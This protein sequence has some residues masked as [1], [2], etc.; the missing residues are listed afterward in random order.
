MIERLY[1]LARPWL[2]QMDAE[3][4][5]TLTIAALGLS[6]MWGGQ[7]KD[8]LRLSVETMGIRFPNPVGLA[9]GFDKNADVPDAML[10]L[11][12]GFVEAGT[13]TPLPQAGNPKPRVFRLAEDRGVI[14]RL[15]FNNEGLAA[16]KSRLTARRGR[17]GIV[18]INAGANKDSADRIADYVNGMAQLGPLASYVTIN[19]SS[20]NTPGLRGLQN[21]DELERLLDAVMAARAAHEVAGPTLLKIAPDLDEQAIKDIV[22]TVIDRRLDGLIV[23]NTTISRPDTLRSPERGET[24]G[25]SGAPLMALSTDT[26][27]HVAWEAR[28]RLCLIG[29]G[30]I[31]SGA[32]AYAKIKAGA[33]LVQLYSAL[34]YEGPGLVARIKRE[35]LRLVIDDGYPDLA[36]AIA[37][38]HKAYV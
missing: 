21:R 32:D 35:L 1:G 28:G 31:A 3:R 34:A 5:H 9:A 25:L 16:A 37:A 23:S 29:V 17:P 22:A 24:G 33:T 8:D 10:R 30:G 36:A 7:P 18:G 14:N 6:P 27:R 38:H 4:A 26:L 2:M 13:V 19:I 15:G 11:G 20:P 12:F